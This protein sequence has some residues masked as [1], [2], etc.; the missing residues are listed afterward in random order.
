MEMGGYHARLEHA[1]FVPC[2][3]MG[4]MLDGVGAL[5]SCNGNYRLR[6][7]PPSQLDPHSSSLVAALPS[8]LSR[9]RTAL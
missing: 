8:P 6:R 7:R 2:V 1:K 9:P 3:E 5:L 4:R